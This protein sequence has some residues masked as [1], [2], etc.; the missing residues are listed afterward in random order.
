MKIEI[1]IEKK[2]REEMGEWLQTFLASTY[3]LY[4]KTQN[5]HW[6]VVGP[7]FFSLHQ[8]F[9]KQYEEMAEAVDEIAERIRALGQVAE[10]GFEPFLKRSKIKGGKGDLPAEKMLR[11]LIEGHESLAKMG[12]PWIAKA[13]GLKDEVSADLLI[14]RLTF[15]EKAAWILRSCL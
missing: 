10:G 5:F 13:Q 6:N 9:Q 2:A 11:E 1:G 8:L 14:Q 7:Q 15:H 3:A 4:L 12:R